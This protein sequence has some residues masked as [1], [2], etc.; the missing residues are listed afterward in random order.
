MG[1]DVFTI[2]A[3]V[4]EFLGGVVGGRVQDIIDTDALG[5]GLEIYAG[6]KRRYLYLSAGAMQPRAHL[7]D[8]KLRRGIDKTR[9]IG[10]VVS[11]LY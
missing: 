7:V 2:A 11:S 8:S 1:F 9:A 5:L 10:P 3:M 6:G 4:D